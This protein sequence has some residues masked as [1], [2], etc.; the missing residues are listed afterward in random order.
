MKCIANAVLFPSFVALFAIAW[1]QGTNVN[2]DQRLHGLPVKLKALPDLALV[3]AAKDLTSLQRTEVLLTWL[4]E[5]H[6]NPSPT[7][8]GANGAPI[9]SAYVEA[10]IVQS[11]IGGQGDLKAAWWLANSAR[12]RSIHVRRAMFLSLGGTDHREV[13]NSLLDTAR[14][15]SNPHFR[16][17]AVIWL[18]GKDDPRI[19][20]VLEDAL[21]DPYVLRYE[22]SHSRLADPITRVRTWRPVREAAE[23]AI[24]NRD[25]GLHKDPTRTASRRSALERLTTG[26][27][28]FARTNKT[29][30][31]QLLSVGNLGASP[32]A[33][34][35]LTFSITHNSGDRGCWQ[36]R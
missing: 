25:A 28:T 18:G 11:L 27:D 12:L 6:R 9:D 13:V 24:R 36:S 35:P 19:S 10:Q 23:E 21:N 8:P 14:N 34:A 1:S 16:A 29:I 15:D 7:Q 22:N 26:L 3:E 32:R 5:E 33:G 4:V 20:K 31:N 17:L 2:S 30:L